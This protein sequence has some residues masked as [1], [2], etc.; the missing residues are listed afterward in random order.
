MSD[1]QSADLGF[2]ISPTWSDATNL[3]FKN[4]LDNIQSGVISLDSDGVVT[5]FNAAA[6]EIVGLA[7]E[8]VVGRTL[9]EVFSEMEGADNFTDVIFDA[10][11]DTLVGHQRV[12]EAT[13]FGKT[14]SLSVATSYLKEE[15]TGETVRIGVVVVFNDISEI[16]ELREKE[17]HLAKEL[18]AKHAELRDAYVSLEERNRELSTTS[19]RRNLL[20]LAA[21]VVVLVLFLG[22]GLYMW[23]YGPERAG[24][25]AGSGA[26]QAVQGT[27]ATLVIEPGPFSSTITVAGQLAPRREIEVTSPMEGTVATVHFEY[28][29]QVAE[30]QRLVDLDV[31][32]IQIEYRDAQVAHIKARDRLD[33]LED[34]SNHV[35]VSRARRVVSRGRIDLEARKNKLSQTAFLL[36]EGLIPASEHEAAEREYDNQLLDLQAAV[37]DLQVVLA[38]GDAE[39]QVARLE[40]K[41]ARTRLQ[42]LE[43]VMRNAT[44][45]APVAGVIMHPERSDSGTQG[46]GRGQ[47]LAKGASVK[48][49]EYLVSIGDLDGFTVVGMVDEV[50]VATIRPGHPATIVGDAFPGIE[51]QGEIVRVSSQASQRD[52]RHRL[53][54]FEV[55]AAV[56][57]L[58][59]EQRR[60]L[61]LGMSA[62]LEVVVYDTTDALL[63]PI[64]AV[65]FVGDQPR[66]RV[67]DRTLDTVRYADVVTGMT[68]IDSVEIVAGIKAGDEVVIPA[69]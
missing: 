11:Y 51:L 16:R 29:E 33:E 48:Q 68:N 69:Q 6:S 35:E 13:F 26:A 39:I 44:V 18:Q 23:N 12:V 22:V 5:T 36:E 42:K 60:Q 40:L 64:D 47:H 7:G 45:H 59:A 55:T 32:D 41:N 49:G 56:K 28:G 8:A 57:K 30:G 54:F 66:L 50:D 37:E 31:T 9:V 1:D 62:T 38:K 65:E 20:R 21:S 61:R 63:V 46:S 25:A 2:R 15:R 3:I 4:V 24:V 67:K 52:E 14:R 43:D 19:R 34:W 27:F 10:V 53:P 17:L 58:N